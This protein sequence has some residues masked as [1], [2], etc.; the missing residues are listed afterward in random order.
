MSSSLTIIRTISKAGSITVPVEIRR[1]L[2][3]HPKMAVEMT[4]TEDQKI[5]IGAHQEGCVICG[6]LEDLRQV[7]SKKVCAACAHTLSN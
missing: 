1:A 2:D 7:K 4:I 3:L 6:S 5:V